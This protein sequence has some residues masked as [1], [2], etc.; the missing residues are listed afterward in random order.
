MSIIVFGS[1]NIDLVTRVSRLPTA[2]ETLLGHSFTTVPGGKGA[3]Q[4]VGCAKLGAKTE[5]IGRVGGDVFGQAL[6]DSL[7]TAGVD[8]TNV[9]VDQEAT[10][11]V[12]TISV[13]DSAENNIIVVPGA[14]G[15]IDQTDLQQLEQQLPNAKLLLLQLEIPVP[16]VVQAAELAQQAGVTVILDPAPAANIPDALYQAT[17]IITPNESEA[18]QLLGYPID[19]IATA[20]QAA[21]ELHGRGVQIAIIKLGANGCVVA[22]GQTTTHYPSRKVTAVDTVAAGDAFNAG[23]AAALANNKSLP[24]AIQ[25]ALSAG[26]YAVTQHGAQSAMP[27][28]ADLQTL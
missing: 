16:M 7:Q 14:N 4:A 11:G 5:M 18:A 24:D 28:Q 17:S 25:Q 10:S 22:D 26:A 21:E 27:T 23:L 15:R 6:L 3:N 20:K 2:G 12:A 13:A 8:T 9:L 19:S 1:I